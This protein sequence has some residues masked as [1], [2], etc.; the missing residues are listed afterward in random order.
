M[1]FLTID[2]VANLKGK[3]VIVRTD[4]NVRVENG[5]VAEEFRIKKTLPTIQFLVDAGAKVILVS[6]IDEKEGGT[7]LPV[8]TYLLPFFPKLRF[9]PD[10]FSPDAK[11]EVQHLADGGVLL[12]ENLRKW[13]GEV[14]C[15]PSFAKHLASFGEIFV[16]DG[17][18]VSH[19]VHASVVG[20]AKE[21]PAYGGLLLRDEVR[22]LSTSFTPPHPFLFILGGA[23][24][25]T[26]L[27]LVDKFSKTADAVFV[28]GALA[29]DLFKAKGLF[30]GDSLVSNIDVSA[31]LSKPNIFLPIDVRTQHKGFYY[32]KKPNEISVNERIW[33][34][35]PETVTD[36]K[37][38]INEAKLI[39]WN[40]PMGNY[41]QGFVSGTKEL[42]EVI[43]QSNAKT[44]VGGGDVVTV[45]NSLH[46]LD[47]FSFVSTGGAAMLEFLSN[48]TL[49]GIEVLSTQKEEL[50][51]DSWLSKLFS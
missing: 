39:V 45:L 1:K 18:A 36:L 34:I 9:V 15:T 28:G 14:E 3:R 26:K 19:R 50:Q 20:I 42:A 16:N 48:E 43:V 13:P 44:I 35:G 7:L 12:F 41:E 37:R 17:F 5:L 30:V 46:M 21:L 29:N 33:D 47:T 49:P 8:A 23:K 11:N 2:T 31:Y 27:P 4:F 40:G 51:K 25:E 24:F 22:A 32:T 6:H 10:V 38:S